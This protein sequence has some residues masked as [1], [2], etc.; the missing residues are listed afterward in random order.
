MS[1]GPSIGRGID[2]ARVEKLHLQG[3]SVSVI[4]E[5]L[6]YSPRRIYDVVAACKARE[7]DKAASAIND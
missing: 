7:D 3:L 5:R 1:R 4:A 2:R 6:G